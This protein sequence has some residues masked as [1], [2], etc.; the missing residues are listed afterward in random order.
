MIAPAPRRRLRSVVAA[1]TLAAAATLSACSGDGSVATGPRSGSG[2]STAP[3]ADGAPASP[4]TGGTADAAALAAAK[5]RAGIANC[6]TTKAGVPPH[7]DGL[8]DLRLDCLGGGRP[9]Q[10]ADLRGTPT[11]I[12]IWAQW[13]RP[14]R[15]EAPHLAAIARSAGDRVRFLGIDYDDPDPAAAIAFARAAGWRYPQLQ[16]PDKQIQSRLRLIGVPATVFVA[17]DGSISYR[18]NGPFRS[19]DQLRTAIHDHLGVTL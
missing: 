18:H 4:T 8:P 7:S 10:L 5:R 9:V 16:D 17:A 13:C 19:D 2:S 11:V 3:S 6:P 14:C 12:N 15:Q 1:V